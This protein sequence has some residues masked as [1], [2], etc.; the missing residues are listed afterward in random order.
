MKTRIEAIN[1]LITDTDKVIDVGCDS[2]KLSNLLAKRGIHSIAS[3]LRK[4]II[5]NCI[6]N[7]SEE[8]KHYID[9]R[10][11]N[12]L[13]VLNEKDNINIAVL[14]GM[15]TYLILNILQNYQ[16]PKI[17]TISNN[18]HYLLRKEMVK[19][20]YIISKEEIIKENKK[21]YN[22][23]EFVTGKKEYTEKDLYV[24]VNH[25]NKDLFEEYKLYKI[26]KLTLLLKNVPNER[27]EGIQNEIN[28]L[29]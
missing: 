28:M 4:N 3:D 24:G 21:Y 26:K 20:G 7:T 8:L 17:I 14:S 9:Y 5:D 18:N 19:R 2:A 10:V 27:K 16:I 23:I 29:S 12:G 13:E 15:G 1:N 11:G 6:N 25:I 22:L